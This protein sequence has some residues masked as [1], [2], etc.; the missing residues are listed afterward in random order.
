MSVAWKDIMDEQKILVSSA[1]LRSVVHD[2]NNLLA[3]LRGAATFL[4]AKVGLDDVL[5]ARI[6]HISRCVA[7]GEE[8]SGR[9]DRLSTGK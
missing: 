1:E 5:R 6:D 7:R 8:I 9:L 2:L 4:G 3:A